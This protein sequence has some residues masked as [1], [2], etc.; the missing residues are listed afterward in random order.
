MDGD[1]SCTQNNETSNK[2]RINYEQGDYVR[3][4]WAPAKE[5][6]VAKET[7]RALKGNRFAVLATDS[8]D[9]QGFIRRA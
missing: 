6:E 2:K 7:E 4:V 3:C 9:R 1:R 8:E 5:G